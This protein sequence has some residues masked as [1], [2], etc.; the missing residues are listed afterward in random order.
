ME[1][2][3]PESKKIKLPSSDY[4][5]F[6]LDTN[7]FSLSD[8]DEGNSLVSF[9]PDTSSTYDRLMSTTNPIKRAIIRVGYQYK[10]QI[11]NI[12][13]V[14]RNAFKLK[15]QYL[16][17]VSKPVRDFSPILSLNGHD[18]L[19]K[20]YQLSFGRDIDVDGLNYWSRELIG[21]APKEAVVY[22]VT[23]SK[24]YTGAPIR[25]IDQ[26]R[27]A[28]YRYKAKKA[29]KKTPI[30]GWLIKFIQMPSQFE[31]SLI[32][33]NLRHF[34]IRSEIQQSNYSLQ[35]SLK[36][37]ELQLQSGLED[38]ESKLE[39]LESK[40]GNLESK[41]ENLEN[42]H[43]PLMEKMIT[44][45]HRKID[46]MA[47]VSNKILATP[48]PVISGF[49]GGVNVIQT[50]RFILGV[51]SEEWRLGAFLAR[52]GG[53]EFGSE[54]VFESLLKPGMVVI[55]LGA[56][57]GVYTILALQKGCEVHSFEPTPRIFNLLEE[58]I[59]VNGFEPSGKAHTY[60]LAITDH[61]GDLTFYGFSA[62][63]GHNSIYKNVESD[64]EVKVKSD[65]LDHV[66]GDLHQIDFIKMDIEGAELAALNGMTNILNANPDLK[67]IMEFGPE[68]MV[69]ASVDPSV[70][71]DWLR[72]RGFSWKV[73]N[74]QSGELEDW[75]DS[76][77]LGAFSV[78]LLLQRSFNG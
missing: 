47:V 52:Y 31:K 60:Q 69:A 41:L 43:V 73:I 39:D 6:R 49:P 46:E 5:R 54:K 62:K 40:L 19:G 68:N 8:A 24:E 32:E 9:Y 14:R 28:Y 21:G 77:L 22:A 2:E 63:S 13:W 27:N 1:E 50:P 48:I 7:S 56:N 10:E 67:I 55:D 61:I 36:S 78:N 34:E 65:T 4:V 29:L 59:A 75:T 71:I 18:F 12:P 33:T 57:L 20:L 35:E 74:E 66:L 76:Q 38:L 44:D 16:S 30:L 53:F 17:E 11:K 3:I 72:S 58:N 45:A 26:Y 25:N 42:G 15:A 70:V 64:Y 51:P 37:N 23:K